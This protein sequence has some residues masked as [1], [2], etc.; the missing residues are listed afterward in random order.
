MTCL[1]Q[2]ADVIPAT[3]GDTVL[4]FDPGLGIPAKSGLSVLVT[5]S[6]Q[7]EV[8]TDGYSVSAGSVPAAAATASKAPAPPQQ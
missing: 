7:A 3:V 2:I 8:Y 1:N 4:P 5:G 6:P